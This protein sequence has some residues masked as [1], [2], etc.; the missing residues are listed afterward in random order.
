MKLSSPMQGLLDLVND[1]EK[2]PPVE[3]PQKFLDELN[4]FGEIRSREEFLDVVKG[5][6]RANR[7]AT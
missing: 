1:I 4:Q 3:V 7:A 2:P 6:L 5:Q